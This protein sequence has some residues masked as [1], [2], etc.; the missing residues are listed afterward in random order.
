MAGKKDRAVVSV[1][2]GL[3]QNQ[4]SKMVA[5]ITKTKG[6]YA[7]LSRGTIAQGSISDIGRL[8]GGGQERLDGR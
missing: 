2:T 3:T 4:A 6:Y 8:L 1:T 5:G 7:P